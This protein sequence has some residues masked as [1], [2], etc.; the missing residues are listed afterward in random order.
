MRRRRQRFLPPPCRLAAATIRATA[1]ADVDMAA[2]IDA[3]RCHAA[4]TADGRARPSAVGRRSD[5]A[6][7][8]RRREA[9]AA[10]TSGG[11]HAE[12]W[13]PRLTAFPNL[14]AS[15][16]SRGRPRLRPVP[17]GRSGTYLPRTATPAH[18]APFGPAFRFRSA[19]ISSRPPVGLYKSF[20][21]PVIFPKK[22]SSLS[23]PVCR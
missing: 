3:T 2:A 20:S 6:R 9:T 7:R 17:S 18:A 16:S 1:S 21:P 10:S 5:R 22:D 8:S 14:C 4:T 12:G 15:L 19:A 11:L 13:Q 23:P